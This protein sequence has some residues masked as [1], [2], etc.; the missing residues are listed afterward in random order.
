ME[1]NTLGT[2]DSEDWG[3]FLNICDVINTTED[4]PKDAVRALRKRI[5]KNYNH[6]ELKISLSLLEV[7][8]QNCRPSF[9]SLIVKKD[10]C[11]AVL[12]KLLNPKYNLPTYLQNR[13]LNFIMTW[14]QGFGGSVDVS[15]VKEVYL[16]LIKKGIQFP[17]AQANGEM[18][19]EEEHMSSHQASEKLPTSPSVP[20][21]AAPASRDVTVLLAPEQI[22]K[23]YS[24]LDM[25]KM[26][27]TVMSAILLENVPGSEKAEDMDLLQQLNKTCREMQ[28][29]IQELLIQVQNDDVTAELVQVNDDLNNAFLRYERF[30]RNRTR[31]SE[32]DS[33]KG[34]LAQ[35]H[36]TPSA[37]A[38]EL[39]DLSYRSFP[40]NVPSTAPESLTVGSEIPASSL[41][42]PLASSE[43]AN[44][45][46]PGTAN[47]L[48]YPQLNLLRVGDSSTTTFALDTRR[49]GPTAPSGSQYDNIF[50]PVPPKPFLPVVQPLHPN[51]LLQN[52]Q[53]DNA[54]QRIYDD[55]AK[56]SPSPPRY[57]EVIEFD[58]LANSNKTEVIYEE[59][60][61]FL[62]KPDHKTHSNC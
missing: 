41:L 37:P 7:C 35:N 22:G 23:L 47:T 56:D 40:S 17:S 20:Y 45:T 39:I 51:V 57:Y 38:S 30:S 62:D 27:V 26:N 1:N 14:S 48:L 33:G 11:K 34:I 50:S 28:E 19:M 5:S 8:M 43:H 10:F 46:G 12:V 15:D 2:N 29:R 55:V 6:K 54:S 58:P 9:Q 60:D 24:E 21:S 31:I 4:G 44:I 53:T 52:E 32:E 36:Y 61:S 13:I 18:H 3:Q 59:I 25:V 49:Y 42:S 16:E